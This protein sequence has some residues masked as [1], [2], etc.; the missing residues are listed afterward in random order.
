MFS[1]HTFMFPKFD[2]AL[3][4]RQFLENCGTMIYLDEEIKHWSI[5]FKKQID[6]LLTLM[7]EH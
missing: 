7:T 6:I 5:D 3:A 4:E 2:S 1:K